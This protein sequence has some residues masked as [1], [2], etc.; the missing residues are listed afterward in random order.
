MLTPSSVYDYNMD[1]KE[2]KLLK[3]AEIIGKGYDQ[4]MY[5]LLYTSDAADE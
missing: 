5:C 1:T 4:N 2:K 3:Q